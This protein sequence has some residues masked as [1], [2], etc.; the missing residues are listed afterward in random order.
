MEKCFHF[1]TDR[2]ALLF[3]RK[4]ESVSSR[5]RDRNSTP[6]VC[7]LVLEARHVSAPSKDHLRSFGYK[8][9]RRPQH[10]FLRGLLFYYLLVGKAIFSPSQLT[11]TQRKANCD[12]PVDNLLMPISSKAFSVLWNLLHLN[13]LDIPFVLLSRSWL[14]MQ[15][16]FTLLFAVCY[17]FETE[18]EV[19]WE[20]YCV[21]T[22]NI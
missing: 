18:L 19:G 11:I 3:Q 21:Y 2:G 10:S 12:F 17:I 4:T 9:H 14:S 7:Q 16:I 8:G 20:S 6:A 5:T 13:V 22:G 1:R 15:K